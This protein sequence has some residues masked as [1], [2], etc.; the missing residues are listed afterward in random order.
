MT[1][2]EEKRLEQLMSAPYALC[3]RDRAQL[4]KLLKQRKRLQTAQTR[5]AQLLAQLHKI[6][7]A[8]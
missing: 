6:E 5:V 7:T 2:E 4:K 3:K 1:N 8:L